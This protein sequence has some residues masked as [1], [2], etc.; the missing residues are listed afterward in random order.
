MAAI[1]DGVVFAGSID[2]PDVIVETDVRGFYSLVVGRS[3]DDVELEG[4]S[5]L[6]EQLLG[7]LPV[8]PAAV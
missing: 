4:D 1:V 7:N 8:A 3:M 5:D 2:D 6:L